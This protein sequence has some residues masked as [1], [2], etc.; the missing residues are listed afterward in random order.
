MA[1]SIIEVNLSLRL[2]ERSGMVKDLSI[3]WT[4]DFGKLR[5]VKKMEGQYVS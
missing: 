5:P 2:T 1:I 4:Y 3:K